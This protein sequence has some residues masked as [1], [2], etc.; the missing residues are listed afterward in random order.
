[1]DLYVE[2]LKLET[3][4]G[5]AK[6]LSYNI[7]ASVYALHSAERDQKAYVNKA[8]SLAFNLKKN[9]VSYQ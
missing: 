4:D 2:S 5:V 9:E 7:E 1:M 3:V 8:R 6:F